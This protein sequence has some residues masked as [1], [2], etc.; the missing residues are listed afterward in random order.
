MVGRAYAVATERGLL[1]RTQEDSRR[2]AL[3]K[4]PGVAP[5][6][7]DDEF[8]LRLRN[9]TRSNRRWRGWKRR[10]W[11][12]CHGGRVEAT[13]QRG[14]YRCVGCAVREF[15]NRAVRKLDLDHSSA[16]VFGLN[17]SRRGG[18]VGGFS[19][20]AALGPFVVRAS[21]SGSSDASC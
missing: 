6:F 1:W 19:V 20:C 16:P 4:R 2:L 14:L 9:A 12:S 13:P 8:G 10:L 5:V 7:I 15:G 18:T 17:F 11:H 21:S 3:R